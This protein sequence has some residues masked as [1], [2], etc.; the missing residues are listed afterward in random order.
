MKKVWIMATMRW[1][2]NA[3]F[4]AENLKAALSNR[5]GGT[6]KSGGRNC[7]LV[8][9]TKNGQETVIVLDGIGEKAE[10]P[11]LIIRMQKNNE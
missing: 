5:L 6:E 4:G 3:A 9:I 11:C 1:S 10:A 8:V 7:K 2:R